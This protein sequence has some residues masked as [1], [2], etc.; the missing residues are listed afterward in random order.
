[1]VKGKL[2]LVLSSATE[3]KDSRP[4]NL[5]TRSAQVRAPSRSEALEDLRWRNRL[6]AS[7]RTVVPS[8]HI[9]GRTS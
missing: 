8:N 9:D 1:M 3:L 2:A 4:P 7:G 5:C 6:F